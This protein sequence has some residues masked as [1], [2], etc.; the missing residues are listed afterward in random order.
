[1]AKEVILTA[2]VEGLGIEGD[3]VRV[4]DGYAR[5]FLMP[6]KLAAPVSDSVRRQLAGLRENRLAEQATELEKAETIAKKL[7][8][9]SCTIPVKTHD[10]GKLFGSVSAADIAKVITEAGVKVDR[11]EVKLKDPIHELGVFD[12]KIAVHPK[13]SQAVKVW[14]VEE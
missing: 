11:N 5:N 1:M 3:V 9:I 6:R 12:V 13:V 10:G 14:I 7:A 4:S 8:D 2:P